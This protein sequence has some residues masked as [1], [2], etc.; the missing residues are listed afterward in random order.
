[1]GKNWLTQMG[2][3]ESLMFVGQGGR[4]EIHVLTDAF[5][6][7]NSVARPAGWKLGSISM[8]QF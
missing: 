3:L 6:S 5:L 1:M 4:L 7:V 8:L 2:R